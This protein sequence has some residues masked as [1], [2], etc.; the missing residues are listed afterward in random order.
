MKTEKRGRGRPPKTDED[1]KYTV[2]KNLRLTPHLSDLIDA[3][4]LE[5]NTTSSEILRQAVMNYLCRNMSDTEI[6]H[7]SIAENTRKIR[8]LEDKI[9]LLAL[10]IF[11][12]TRFIMSVMPSRQVKADEL[13]DNEFEQFKRECT[14]ALRKNHNGLLEGMILDSYERSG[15]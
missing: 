5:Q 11:Q 6:V 7:A 3:K 8:Y 1:M 10:I 13:V 14:R 15:D 12:Q 2:L 9:E 4:A